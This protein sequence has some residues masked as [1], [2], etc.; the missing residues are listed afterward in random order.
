MFTHSD[1]VTGF[2][3][4]IFSHWS[5]VQNCPFFFHSSCFMQLICSGKNQ[6]PN[7][8]IVSPVLNERSVIDIEHMG[9]FDKVIK[10]TPLPQVARFR[11]KYFFIICMSLQYI[12]YTKPFLLCIW[13][14]NLTMFPIFYLASPPLLHIVRV[15]V[16]KQVLTKSRLDL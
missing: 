11:G 7:N 5:L 1:S 15:S 3:S 8:K 2:C 14:W 12:F 9:S 4:F 13:N 10:N 6:P 16:N